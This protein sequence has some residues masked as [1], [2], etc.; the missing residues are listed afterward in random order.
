MYYSI[1]TYT[2]YIICLC[3]WAPS[4]KLRFHFSIGEGIVRFCNK[5]IP[6]P[7]NNTRTHS[8][9]IRVY[10]YIWIH[11][12]RTLWNWSCWAYS[13]LEITDNKDTLG[14]CGHLLP[15][16]SQI[17]ICSFLAF[18]S[19]S[20]VDLHCHCLC[21]KQIPTVRLFYMFFSRNM[22]PPVS[23]RT[24]R[25]MPWSRNLWCLWPSTTTGA[26][27]QSYLKL[28]KAIPSTRHFHSFWWNMWSVEIRSNWKWIWNTNTLG[29][30]VESRHKKTWAPSI[31]YIYILL[32]WC[33]I[34]GWS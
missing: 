31:L 8:A 25:L 5:T 1:W 23:R 18:G 14:I 7:K 16:A 30:P 26:S 13:Q 20:F 12:E 19:W 4:E 33:S 22:S 21:T 11:E 24:Y 3:N 15:N 17:K 27:L 28:H 2:Y 10:T 34:F 32:F 29:F 9:R 6:N